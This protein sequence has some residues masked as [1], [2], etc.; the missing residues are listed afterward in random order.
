MTFNLL[1]ALMRAMAALSVSRVAWNL[2]DDP[3]WTLGCGTDAFGAGVD[4]SLEG[5]DELGHLLVALDAAEGA[6][7]VE[8]AGRGPAQNHLPVTPTG[9]IAIGRFGDGDHRFDG[10]GRGQRPGEAAVEA[11]PADGEHL[12]QPLPQRRGRT[13]MT[14]L[15]LRGKAFGIAQPGVGVGMVERLNQLGVHPRL[16]F[17]RQVISD[18]APLM[19]SAPLN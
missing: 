7:G 2:G 12:L 14:L 13:G 15:Q 16:L 3:W 10:V 19:Q 11:Q 9:Y 5:G 6:F 1:K 8:H 18:V 4:V 17:V